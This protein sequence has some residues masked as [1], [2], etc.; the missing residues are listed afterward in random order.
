MGREPWL[1]Q[2]VPVKQVLC[3]PKGTRSAGSSILALNSDLRVCRES[4][5]QPDVVALVF[6]SLE[7]RE[8]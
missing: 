1:L 7:S 6:V 3:L 8:S 2:R 4:H 5:S